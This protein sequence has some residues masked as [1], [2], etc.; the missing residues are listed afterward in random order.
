MKL[1]VVDSSK[2]V[3]V[4]GRFRTRKRGLLYLFLAKIPRG[5]LQATWND[6]GKRHE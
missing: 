1:E 6:E 2:E 3:D 5:Q 4:A